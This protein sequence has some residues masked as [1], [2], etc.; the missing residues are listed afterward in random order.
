MRQYHGRISLKAGA[1]A[2]SAPGQRAP[3]AGGK[4]SQAEPRPTWFRVNDSAFKTKPSPQSLGIEVEYRKYT[5]SEVC[6]EEDLDILWFWEV[7]SLLLNGAL[8]HLQNRPI[9]RCSRLYSRLLWTSS[10]FRQRL[11]FANVCFPQQRRRTLLNE[12]G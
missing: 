3:V 8:T 4:P 6:S 12:T 5:S 2:Q 10:Q 1:V 11:C 9:K 7:R